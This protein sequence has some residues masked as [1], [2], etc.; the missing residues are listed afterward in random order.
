MIDRW[1]RTFRT[2][3]ALTRGGPRPLHLVRHLVRRQRVPRPGMG[4]SHSGLVVET[5]HQLS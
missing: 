3:T 5:F 4:Q 1:R 2:L